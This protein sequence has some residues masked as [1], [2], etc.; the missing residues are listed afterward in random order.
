MNCAL[1][2]GVTIT[3]SLSCPLQG[4]AMAAD[5]DCAK[6]RFICCS[7]GLLMG[8]CRGRTGSQQRQVMLPAHIWMH[9]QQRGPGSPTGCELPGQVPSEPLSQA[10]KGH[11]RS[12]L[13]P[14][15]LQRPQRGQWG[16]TRSECWRPWDGRGRDWQPGLCFPAVGRKSRTAEAPSSRLLPVAAILGTGTACLGGGGAAKGLEAEGLEEELASMP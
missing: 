2:P 13:G 11:R 4:L 8:R 7:V 9:W 6:R 16:G 15:L 1:T 5:S 14:L 12:S 10:Q 3:P